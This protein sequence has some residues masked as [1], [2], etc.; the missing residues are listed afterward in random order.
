MDIHSPQERKFHA[1]ICIWALASYILLQVLR[2][3]NQLA[4]RARG[5]VS[6]P[7]YRLLTLQ[8]LLSNPQ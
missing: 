4:G 7:E 1:R 8:G 5:A 6:A 3:L 2:R